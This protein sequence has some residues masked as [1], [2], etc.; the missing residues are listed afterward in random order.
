MH[1]QH[2]KAHFF[3]T[4]AWAHLWE[5]F[6]ILYKRLLMCVKKVVSIMASVP[7]PSLLCTP[8]GLVYPLLILLS[9]ALS[10]WSPSFVSWFS[11]GGTEKRNVLTRAPR[12][13]RDLTTL[14]LGIRP[15]CLS[16]MKAPDSYHN[17]N[18]SEITFIEINGISLLQKSE[19]KG[20]Y[21]AVNFHL[22][23]P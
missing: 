5:R 12:T 9:F 18:N 1:I 3:F 16:S 22:L 19:I 2:R 6:V 23:K 13:Q 17:L 4:R 15:V 20:L 8:S 7:L 11:A 14:G 21:F 10:F